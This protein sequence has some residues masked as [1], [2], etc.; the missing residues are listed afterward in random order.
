MGSAQ[1][2]SQM[3]TDDKFS[4]DVN[5]LV[6]NNASLK[7]QLN[8]KK[9]L[10]FVHGNYSIDFGDY[11]PSEPIRRQTIICQIDADISSQTTLFVIII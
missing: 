10:M 7:S 8:Y 6:S 5:H 2:T 3:D 4:D 9:Q 11:R 1:L